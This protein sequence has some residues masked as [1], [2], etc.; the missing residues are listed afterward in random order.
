MEIPNY[1]SVLGTTYVPLFT[2]SSLRASNFFNAG[3]KD[4]AMIA[5]ANSSYAG[6]I[7]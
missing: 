5:M 1:A 7:I 2:G 3:R 6:P 4:F